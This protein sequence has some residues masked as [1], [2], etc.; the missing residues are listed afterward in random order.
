MKIY[1]QLTSLSVSLFQF[2]D[3]EIWRFLKKLVEFTL[4]KQKKFQKVPI[5]QKR[6]NLSTKN[7]NKKK[8]RFF[9]NHT[10]SILLLILITNAADMSHDDHQV[11]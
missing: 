4:E 8:L 5:L 11:W 6:Q 1:I 3:I 2:F 9:S 10:S 7:K